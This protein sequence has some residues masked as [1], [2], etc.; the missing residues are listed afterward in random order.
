MIPCKNCGAPVD[1]SD[2]VCPHCGIK[3]KISGFV[4]FLITLGIFLLIGLLIYL[5]R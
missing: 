3:L 5:S 2:K 4:K 1:L